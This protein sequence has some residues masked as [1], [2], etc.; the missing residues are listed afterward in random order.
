MPVL[1]RS[2]RDLDDVVH[3][4]R[5]RT[6]QY[7][8]WDPLCMIGWDACFLLEQDLGDEVPTCLFCAVTRY[9]R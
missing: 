9:L 7:N 3:L 8:I 4:A 2:H 5:E 1:Y 6:S